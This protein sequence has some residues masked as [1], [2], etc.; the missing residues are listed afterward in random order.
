MWLGSSTHMSEARLSMM[1]WGSTHCTCCSRSHSPATH[2]PRP[3]TGNLYSKKRKKPRTTT[4][5]IGIKRSTSFRS[6]IKLCSMF[7]V[8]DHIRTKADL[9]QF[10]KYSHA[11]VVKRSR[12]IIMQQLWDVLQ[13]SCFSNSLPRVSPMWKGECLLTH[14]A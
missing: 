3:R 11:E 4:A 7:L 9:P 5:T 14:S 8:H 6:H 13:Q 10:M 2:C 12:W 1:R